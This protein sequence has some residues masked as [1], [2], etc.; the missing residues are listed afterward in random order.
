MSVAK[1]AVARRIAWSIANAPEDDE[2]LSEEDL[3]AIREG[4]E[5]VAAGR[6]YSMEEARQLLGL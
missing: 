3:E 4:D 5:D 2:P 1:D 6:L